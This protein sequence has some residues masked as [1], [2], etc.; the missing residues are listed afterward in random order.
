MR[1]QRRRR[2]SSSDRTVRNR[3]PHS[4]TERIPMS[5]TTDVT[6]EEQSLRNAASALRAAHYDVASDLLEGCEDWSA[7]IAEQAVVLKA[8]IVGRRDPVAAVSY[9]TSVEDLITS[10]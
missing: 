7:E 6:S 3:S 9:L 1:E 10:P 4:S 8:E 2:T 5:T